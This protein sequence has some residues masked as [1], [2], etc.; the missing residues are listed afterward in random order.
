MFQ[1]LGLLLNLFA[2]QGEV[3]RNVAIQIRD[4]RHWQ[5]LMRDA[6]WV[7]W[8]A[9][10]WATFCVL[11]MPLATIVL[12]LAIG[13]DVLVVLSLAIF[14]R[15]YRSKHPHHSPPPGFPPV[16]YALFLAF[17]YS[18]S[19]AVIFTIAPILVGAVLWMVGAT[20]AYY[21][22]YSLEPLAI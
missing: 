12:A 9:A 2:V 8:T 20:S 19:N 22:L 17:T 4:R 1:T 11:L 15:I 18:L 21:A 16:E 6:P 5:M 10:F 13:V 3:A 14:M 7:V